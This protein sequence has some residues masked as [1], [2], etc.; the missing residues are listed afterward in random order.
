MK[1]L[2][3][4]GPGNVFGKRMHHAWSSLAG[5]VLVRAGH[6]AQEGPAGCLLP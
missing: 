4:A 2:A 5:H 3:Q 6:H 1:L